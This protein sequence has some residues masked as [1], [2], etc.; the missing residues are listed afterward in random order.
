MIELDSK[1]W[2]TEVKRKGTRDEACVLKRK[3]EGARAAARPL[4][5][6]WEINGDPC[7]IEQRPVRK[8]RGR[9]GLGVQTTAIHTEAQMQKEQIFRLWLTQEHD[10]AN[11]LV[12][13]AR[14]LQV[15]AEQL[16][17]RGWPTAP[18]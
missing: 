16:S 5:S 13:R 2:T 1:E 9:L 6:D 15:A 4:V 14:H 10:G 18:Q 7:A 3:V 11:E 12:D 8:E 17:R